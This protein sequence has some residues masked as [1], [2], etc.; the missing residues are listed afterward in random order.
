MN[1]CNGVEIKLGDVVVKAK[2]GTRIRL[3][4]GLVI[5]FSPDM[6]VLH[7][8]KHDY[9]EACKPHTLLVVS[10]AVVTGFYEQYQDRIIQPVNS[11]RL[12]AKAVARPKYYLFCDSARTK[13]AAVAVDAH[14]EH[15][16]HKAK[17]LVKAKVLPS[18]LQNTY[19]HVFH[20]QKWEW[21]K[22]G[23][24]KRG[25]ESHGYNPKNIL[26]VPQSKLPAELL[27]GDPVAYSDELVNYFLNLVK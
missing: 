6:V 14:N 23:Y 12:K 13:I 27:S 17:S 26:V 15:N 18:D 16:F 4:M 2:S 24:S 9:P 5:D 21:K 8:A 3:H 22:G 19:G 10:T 7:T 25:F 20:F 1:D 11:K